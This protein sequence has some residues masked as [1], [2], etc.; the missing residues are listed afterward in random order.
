MS[1]GIINPVRDYPFLTQQSAA[2][3]KA[4]RTFPTQQ[5]TITSGTI[6]PVRDYPLVTQ[7]TIATHKVRRTFLITNT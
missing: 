7:Q 6:N 1:Q 2:T 3:H 5:T 4:R